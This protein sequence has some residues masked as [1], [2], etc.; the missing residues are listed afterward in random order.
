MT[1][2][3]SSSQDQDFAERANANQASLRAA[4]KT[5]YDFIVCGAGSSGS[6]IARR[7]AENP[8]VQVL[9]LEAGGDEDVPEVTNPALW[10]TNLRSDRDWAFQAA[11]NP[12]LNGRSIL[13][14]MGKVLGGG[15]SI[16]A[17]VWARGHKSDWDF[18][19]TE[20]KDPAWG[21]ENVLAIYRN[22]EDWKGPPDPEYRGTGGPMFIQ[23][24]PNPSPIASAMLEAAQELGIPSFPNPNGRMMEGDG[25]C[26]YSDSST[27]DGKRHSVFR[28]YTYPYMDRPNLTVLTH[29]V[30]TR[31][32]LEQQQ[33]TGVEIMRDG[34]TSTLRATSEVIL[35]LG[36][37]HTPKVLMCSGIGDQDELR[38]F[39]IPVLQHLPGVGRN[40]QD[41]VTFG[42]IWEYKYPISP[43]NTGSEATMYWKSH[44]T[45]DAP[46]LMFCQA[47]F[48][49]RS[50]AT[51]VLDLPNGGWSMFGGLAR[52]KSRGRVRLSSS[53]PLDPVRLEANTLAHTD[54]I[55]VA[56][57]CAEM[58]RAIG[59]AR[60][61]MPFVERE[62]LPG[63]KSK[64]QLEYYIRDSAVSYW[65]LTCTAKMGHDALS[66]V[67]GSLKVHGIR[68]LRIAD[69]SIMPRVTTGNTMAPCVII[70]ERASQIL[71]KEHC[72]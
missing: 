67:D 21:Y 7:L 31:L 65:H 44:P 13:L 50:P 49:T 20:A 1:S 71:K 33:V 38:Q 64:S 41:H 48:P 51:P 57:V 72:I 26:A 40:L 58:A 60:A 39:S 17:M 62:V 30:V 25:G 43:R 46:D 29:T 24:S 22:I 11:P 27:R 19:A 36:A 32:L 56:L 10:P 68:N 52:P 63:G 55:K 18:F 37:I 3:N 61:F 2:I 28:A 8:S 14:S 42:C 54:D 5:H 53:N 12:H 35:S 59:N 70:G 47:E 4:L 45:L 15:S 6:V 66:V 23:S 9:L 69:G 34:Q 16:N